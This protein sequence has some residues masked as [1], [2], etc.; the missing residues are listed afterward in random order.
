MELSIAIF[1][2]FLIGFHNI[3]YHSFFVCFFIWPGLMKGTLHLIS[4]VKTEIN[5]NRKCFP[6]LDIESLLP[7]K[8]K[9]RPKYFFFS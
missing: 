4:T 6:L 5:Q 2:T 3:F 1:L 9:K 7:G 8:L